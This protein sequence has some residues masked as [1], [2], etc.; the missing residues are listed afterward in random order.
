MAQSAR[1]RAVKTATTLSQRSRCCE[2][3]RAR[4]SKHHRATQEQQPSRTLSKDPHND[5]VPEAHASDVSRSSRIERTMRQEF[6]LRVE[7]S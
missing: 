3:T 6:S 4:Q 2:G 7:C 1:T 5:L